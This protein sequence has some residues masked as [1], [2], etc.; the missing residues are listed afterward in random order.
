MRLT[1]CLYV[2]LSDSTEFSFTIFSIEF[3][4]HARRSRRVL[5]RILYWRQDGHQAAAPGESEIEK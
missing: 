5:K 1:S 3:T 2:S 4:M